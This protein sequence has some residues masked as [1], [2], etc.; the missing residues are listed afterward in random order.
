MLLYLLAQTAQSCSSICLQ[1][2]RTQLVCSHIVVKSNWYAGGSDVA[3]DFHLCHV[4][5]TAL[6]KVSL[7]K[8]QKPEAVSAM[9]DFVYFLWYEQQQLAR[10]A[11]VLK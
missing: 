5:H 10:G 11:Q 6:H 9:L 1:S 7:G 4:V 3:L 8:A 2:P